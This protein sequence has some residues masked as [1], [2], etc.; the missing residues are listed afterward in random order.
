M[1]KEIP[2]TQ[3]KVALVDDEDFECVNQF[4][5]HAH[6]SHGRWYAERMGPR[7]KRQRIKMHRVIANRMGIVDA[8]RVI[9]HRD[10]H[11][12][13]NRRINLRPAT[14]AENNRNQKTFQTNT[15]GLKG[16]SRTN[17]GKPFMA[18]I[19]PDNHCLYLGAFDTAEQAARAYDAAARMFFGEFART[20]Y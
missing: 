6:N 18:R 10:G 15:L 17:R 4:K 8:S 9:D 13:D 1:T 7:P 14:T 2:L 12:L 11:T 16:V 20:N 3:G 5:W 19:S